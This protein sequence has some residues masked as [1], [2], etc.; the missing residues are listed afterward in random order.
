MV[1]FTSTLSLLIFCLLHLLITERGVLKSPTVRVALSISA[2]SSVFVY[3]CLQFCLFTACILLLHRQVYTHC[4]CS[5][6]KSCL[7]LVTPWSV[8][9]QASPSSTISQSL[10]K[11]MS[12]E[13]VIPYRPLLPPSPP[14][15]S[16]PASCSSGASALASVLPMNIQDWFPLGLTGWILLSK[17]L[18]RVF[19]STTVRKHQFFGA[20]LSLWSSCHISTWLLEKW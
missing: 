20:Q 15:L 1:L 2:C 11:L 16:F 18:S 10:L 9:G 6:P 7:T 12:I 13:S 8:A 4:R 19:S 3:F 17:G 5:V 14:A